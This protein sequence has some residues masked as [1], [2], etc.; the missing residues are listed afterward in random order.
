MDIFIGISLTI[1]VATIIAG[2]L[3][4]LRQPLII[5]HIL[6]G[7]LIGSFVLRTN[8]LKEAL[9]IFSQFGVAILLFIIGLSLRPKIL[10]EVG[11]ISLITGIG[12]VVF[13]SLFGFLISRLLGYE[14]ITS[15]YIAVALTFSSTIIILKLLSDKRDLDKLYGKISVGFLLVQDLIAALILIFIS[16]ISQGGDF[17]EKV[18]LLAVKA[19]AIVLTLLFIGRYL[20]PKLSTFF[21]KSQEF[22][23]LFSIAWG[24]G[25][26]SLFHYIGFSIEIGALIA[27][28]AL[29]SSPY[30]LEISS[31]L[32][33]LR[34]FFIILFFILL[35]SQLVI[36]DF[37]SYIFPASIL[38]AFIL[39]GNPLI[40]LVLMGMFGY[41]KKIGFMAGLTVAQISEFSLILV[42]LGIKVGHLNSSILPL[43]TIVGLLT[44]T[45]STYMIIYS[46]KIYPHMSRFLS[47][48]ER[49][50]KNKL[51]ITQEPCDIILLGCNRLGHDF[52]E[53]FQSNKDNFLVVDFDPDMVKRLTDLGVKC[54][55]GDASDGDLLDEIGL[56]KAKMIISTVSDYE[57]NL[58]ILSKVHE[59]NKHAIIIVV[60]H[61]AEEAIELYK[62]GSTYVITPHFLGGKYASLMISKYGFD[63]QKFI[64]EKES[65]IKDLEKRRN[66]SLPNIK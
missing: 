34:D 2:V 54:I 24:L 48:F 33:P 50:K 63:L 16:S 38:T 40:V 44:I 36:Q 18:I 14:V 26:A 19:A 15:L 53:A 47:L 9:E 56:G 41:S 23:F 4:K 22:L 43:V 10:R 37:A 39:I 11:K 59:V 52:V 28:V 5:G 31:K 60:S 46:G 51:P 3:Q 17:S 12:Q 42:I 64:I 25:L 45:A 29:A 57:T 35:G 62:K 66:L 6:T 49:K 7:L 30:S 65:H 1:V 27:G 21:A 13:T 58:F 8:G 20:L 55:Y 61:E 32:K